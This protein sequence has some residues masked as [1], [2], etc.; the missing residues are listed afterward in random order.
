MKR[1]KVD[2][3][4]F[5]WWKAA[6]KVLRYGNHGDAENITKKPLDEIASFR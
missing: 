1:R 6:Q 2:E 4:W 5:V 3:A